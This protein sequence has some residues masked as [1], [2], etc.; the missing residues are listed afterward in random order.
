V[1]NGKRLYE[2]IAGLMF[3]PK[4]AV[5]PAAVV[6][7]EGDGGEKK[8]KKVEKKKEK[9]VKTV[10]PSEPLDKA[11]E[12]A[13]SFYGK[14]PPK[15]RPEWLAWLEGCIRVTTGKLFHFHLCAAHQGH[16]STSVSPVVRPCPAEGPRT[17]PFETE[18]KFRRSWFCGFFLRSERW[19]GPRGGKSALPCN[20]KLV[21][22]PIG[23]GPFPVL[24]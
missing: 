16:H 4:A 23:F 14:R 15:K 7:R 3:P 6:A 1:A 2:A 18:E 21:D 5:A 8:K 10:S 24:L 11:I 22:S 9:K 20:Q 12:H 19:T 13:A 17:G